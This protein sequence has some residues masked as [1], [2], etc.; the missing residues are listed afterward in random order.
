MIPSTFNA[1]N[2]T[3]YLCFQSKIMTLYFHD[4]YKITFESSFAKYRKFIFYSD[5]SCQFI[6]GCLTDMPFNFRFGTV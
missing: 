1:N 2:N 4:P 3:S 5:I 6:A